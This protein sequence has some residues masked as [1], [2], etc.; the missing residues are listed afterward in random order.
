[1]KI[2]L[3]GMESTYHKVFPEGKDLLWTLL[4]YY[5]IRRNTEN[6]MELIRRS[7]EIM[8]DSGAHSFQKGVTVPWDDYTRE[9]ADWIRAND[10]PKIHGYFEMDVD[11]V[12]GYEKVLELREILLKATDKIIPVWHKN[13]GLE[14]FKKMCHE[15]SGRI[16]A[17]TG[18]RNE[19]IRDSQYGMFYAYAHEAGCRVHCLG[20]TRRNVLDQ[21]PFEFADSSSWLQMAAYG[22]APLYLKETEPAVK[23]RFPRG[24]NTYALERKSYEEYRLMQLYYHAKWQH[25]NQD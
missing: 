14:E 4:S 16:I 3:S 21:V 12:I 17:I 23:V 10:Q 5:S 20:M 13:R 11:N 7:Q 15:Y 19:D 6:S 25:I 24:T 8:I 22:T 1:M 2:F 18:F 9:Y